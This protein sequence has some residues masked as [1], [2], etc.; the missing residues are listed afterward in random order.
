MPDLTQH[1]KLPSQYLTQHN[2]HHVQ[3]AGPEPGLLYVLHLH[4]LR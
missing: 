4:E 1:L 3:G 2:R